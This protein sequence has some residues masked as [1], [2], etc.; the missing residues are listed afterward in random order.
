MGLKQLH[1]FGGAIDHANEASATDQGKRHGA[2]R[3]GDRV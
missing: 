1:R 3:R 2:I